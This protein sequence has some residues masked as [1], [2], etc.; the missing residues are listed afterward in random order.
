[1]TAGR[2]STTTRIERA[3]VRLRGQNV[4]V[5]ADLAALYGVPTKALNQAVR[6][7]P[8]RFPQDFMFR[9]TAVEARSLRSQIVTSNA[10]G[11][12][13]H[14]PLVFTEHGVAMLSSVLRSHRAVAVN[15]EIMRAFVQLRRALATVPELALRIDALERRYDGR[16]RG[17]FRVLREL[18]EPPARPP[19][20][21]G[22][23]GPIAPVLSGGAGE[24]RSRLVG[25]R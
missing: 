6:R 16:F 10:R 1:M 13:R 4:M 17:I 9:L 7:N 22:F 3:I 12:R 23:G 11:G 8:R 24:R 5:D 14:R 25:N 18:L 20:R 15:I 2:M 21:I 19:R